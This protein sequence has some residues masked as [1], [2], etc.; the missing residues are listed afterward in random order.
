MSRILLCEHC[1]EAIRSRGELVKVCEPNFVTAE[2]CEE[3]NIT[4]DWCGE[5]DDLHSCEF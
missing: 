5:I 4:C 2:E 1:I 3:H